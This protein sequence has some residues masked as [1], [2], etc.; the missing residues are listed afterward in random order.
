MCS[1]LSP[2]FFSCLCLTL[3][4]RSWAMGTTYAAKRWCLTA[5]QKTLRKEGDMVLASTGKK[6]AINRLCGA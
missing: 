1:A 3:E 4:P 5:G 2:A 6:C